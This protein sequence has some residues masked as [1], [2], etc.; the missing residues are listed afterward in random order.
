MTSLSQ[1]DVRRSCTVL[2]STGLIRLITEIDDNGSIPTRALTRT[3]TGI[4]ATQRRQALIQARTL[5]LVR[6]RHGAGLDLTPAGT[7]LADIYD[8]MARWARHH[9]F[10]A[11]V[12]DFTSRV[13]HTLA[14][15]TAPAALVSENT[16]DGFE[17][18]PSVCAASTGDLAGPRDLLH[19]WVRAHQNPDTDADDELAA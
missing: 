18:A 12:C 8:A 11:P 3:L 10:P 13:Q 5:G 2:S 7:E 16:N 15:L 14:L 4:P 19:Q 1:T 9:S 17:A 6:N